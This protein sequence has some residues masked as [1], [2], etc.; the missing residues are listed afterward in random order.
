[1][2]AC[3]NVQVTRQRWPPCPYIVKTI[4]DIFLWNRKADD[5]ETWYTAL[6]T[7]VLP[8]LFK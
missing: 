8:Y 2:K 5:F 4:E 6:S 3:S 7:R 1:M